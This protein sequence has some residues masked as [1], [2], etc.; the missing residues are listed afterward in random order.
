[1]GELIYSIIGSMENIPADQ[2][3]MICSVAGVVICVLTAVFIDM[4]YR[5]IDTLIGRCFG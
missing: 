5:I 2:I 1:M 4:I 3:S